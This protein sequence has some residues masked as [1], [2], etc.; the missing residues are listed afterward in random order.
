MPG[1]DVIESEKKK[2]AIINL[3]IQLHSSHLFLPGKIEKIEQML[4]K[5]LTARIFIIHS[6]KYIY[7]YISV[8]TQQSSY[9]ILFIYIYI[10]CIDL[11]K[12]YIQVYI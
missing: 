7:I 3:E 5:L 11:Y 8:K 4:K 6:F 10:G 1:L 2:I 9:N 12:K